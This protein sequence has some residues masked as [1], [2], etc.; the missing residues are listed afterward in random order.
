MRALNSAQLIGNLG[1]DVETRAMPSGD[2]VATVSIAMDD[3][4]K[5]RDGKKVEQTEWMTLV[6]FARLAEVAAQYLHKGSKVYVRGKLRTRSW[7]DKETGKKQYRTEVVV[8]D[9]IMLDGASKG[10]R[11]AEDRDQ[12]EDWRPSES[13][14]RRSRESAPAKRQQHDD[15]DED[16]PF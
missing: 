3:S 8:A 4:Y 11:Q 15:F 5:D 12:R 6:F 16:I 7:E 10:D 9:L 2:A 14:G 13:H 1:Q